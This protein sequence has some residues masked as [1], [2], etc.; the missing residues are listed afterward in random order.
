VLI[1]KDYRCFTFTDIIVLGMKKAKRNCIQLRTSALGLIAFRTKSSLE[2]ATVCLKRALFIL[3]H[4][5]IFTTIPRKS[6][7]NLCK[8]VE[9]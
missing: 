9:S 1:E 3:I 8:V 4:T 6:G 2:K 7:V 5:S